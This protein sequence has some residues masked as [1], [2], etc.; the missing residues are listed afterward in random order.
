M[1]YALEKGGAKRLEIS[2]KGNWKEITIR[3]DGEV[4]GTISDIENLKAGQ[5]FALE[6]GSTLKVWL[7]RGLVFPRLQI[8]KNDWPVHTQGFKPAQL[9]SYVYKLIFFFG[10]ANLAIGLSGTLF[11]T[12]LGNLPPAGLLSVIL[13]GLFLVLGFLV[14]RRSMIALVIAAGI[15]AL[16]MVLTIFFP[17]NLPRFALVIGIVF[18]IL[19]LLVMVQGFGA[20]KA[21]KQSKSNAK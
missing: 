19:I 8:Y 6:D 17:P 1:K 21:L 7:S 14:M 16:D 4:I 20:I 9:L 11:H 13:G 18:R 15:L 12:T 3:L 5:E 2:W 10:G